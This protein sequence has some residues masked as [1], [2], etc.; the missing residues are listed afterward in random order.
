MQHLALRMF[1][2][3]A[4]VIMTSCTTSV[5]TF[6]PQSLPTIPTTAV[7][8]ATT[9][10]YLPIIFGPPPP[11]PVGWYQLAGNPQRT[12]YTP[13]IVQ[14]PYQF[15]WIWN[16][17]AGGG[18]GGP[19]SDHLPLPK[20]VQ[21]VIGNGM[22][23][24]G[25]SDGVVHALHTDNGTLAWSRLVGGQVLGTVA[26]HPDLRRVFVGSTNGRLYSLNA[27]DGTIIG[28]Y[29]VG[30]PIEMSPLLANNVIYVGSII[31]KGKNNGEGTSG[32]LV[33][34]NANDLT[35]RW[36]YN[37]GAGLLASPAYTASNGGMVIIAVEDKTVRALRVSD[38]GLVW[39]QTV[40]AGR[41]PQRQ[42][43]AFPD[44]YPAVSEAN[45]VVIIRSY[46]MWQR[47][48][49]PPVSQT[50]TIDEI[51]Q[52]LTQNPTHQSFF[53]LDLATGQPRYVAPVLGGGIG[54][55]DDYYSTPPQV[56]I[57]RLSNSEE[58]A[59]VTWRN[60]QS[61]LSPSNCDNRE[62]GTVGEMDLNTG[63]IRFV[64]IYKNSWQWRIPVD[65]LGS[66]TMAGDALFYSH[67]MAM[68]AVTITDRSPSRG[69]TFTNPILTSKLVAIS[70]TI[71]PGTCNQRD[72]T[73]HYCPT[74]H[75]VNNDSYQ[76]GPGFYIYYASENIYDRFFTPP[77]FGPAID[78]NGVVYWKS[79]DGAIIALAPQSARLP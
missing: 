46:F 42:W 6:T 1:I 18:D 40:N 51:R 24:I 16:G 34:L 63:H 8:R 36:Q 74:A 23:F 57:R 31:N 32:R 17:P 73:R 19:A 49:A 75:G 76:L 67:W 44:T 35:L 60:S 3:C 5:A 4:A 61:C 50:D 38:G 70:N 11:S 26:Y 9:T 53:V 33:A 77:V 20:A 54:N 27:N 28:S 10:T 71:R 39:S 7:V 15:R 69:Q 14:G 52:F 2:L 47:T 58:V 55:N 37:P 48:W 59:Y 66:M 25:H 78:E 22:V 29:D 30:G 13:V 79:V 72:S 41:D 65:E 64:E 62:E 56:V 43:T 68:A 45:G 21:P 12:A